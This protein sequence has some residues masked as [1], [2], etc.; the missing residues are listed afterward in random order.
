M[1]DAASRRGIM[2]EEKHGGRVSRVL[3]AGRIE[4]TAFQETCCLMVTRGLDMMAGDHRSLLDH[5][6]GIK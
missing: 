1:A 4:T 3:F 6:V 2:F 5:R